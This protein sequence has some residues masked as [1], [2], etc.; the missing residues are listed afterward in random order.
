MKTTYLRQVLGGWVCFVS[1]AFA[2]ELTPAH[3]QETQPV[4]TDVRVER[5]NVVINTRVPAGIRRVTLECRDRLGLGT[6][7]PRAVQRTDGAGGVVTFRLPRS[8]SMEV[9]RVRGDSA[10]P[11]PAAFYAGT[12]SFAG[13]ADG[14]PNAFVRL[15]TMTSVPP[16]G[17]ATAT[18]EV[19]ESDIWRIR[20]QTLY[21]FNQLRGLQ[22][23]DIA[24]PDAASVRGTVELPAEGEDLYL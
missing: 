22:V 23:L 9:L 17:E 3:A 11:L 2:A 10:E 6:W 5:T 8:R 12:N 21:F 14:G 24:N 19:V 4:I 18:R 7:E 15:D 20:G 13:Q 16:P 1:F